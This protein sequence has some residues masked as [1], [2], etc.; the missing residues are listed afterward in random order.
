[1]TTASCLGAC[2]GDVL[3]Y[4]VPSLPLVILRVLKHSAIIIACMRYLQ[5]L[6]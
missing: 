5:M 1:M 4:M 3:C 2:P 6:I